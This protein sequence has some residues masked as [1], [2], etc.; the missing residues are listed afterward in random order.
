MPDPTPPPAPPRCALPWWRLALLMLPGLAG[1]SGL[2]FYPQSHLV[3]TPAQLGL[4]YRDVWL[5][6][7]DG[8]RLHGWWLPARG[9]PV[10]GT[11]YFLHG[12]AENIS[13]HIHNVQW[14]PDQ[15]YQVFLLDY[16]GYGRSTG[17]PRLPAVLQD[18]RTG[19]AYLLENPA[20]QG[21]PLFLLGQSLGASLGLYFAATDPQARR[22]LDGV[23][24]DA[25][26]ASYRGIVR[27]VAG[28]SWLTWPLQYP[29]AWRLPAGLDPVDHVA[30]IAPT[31]LLLIHSRQDPIIP[32]VNAERL[33]QAARQPVT[34]RTT[35]GPHTATFNH[36][37]H[38]RF[39]LSFFERSTTA[40]EAN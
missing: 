38:R 40:S 26:F 2:L 8:V 30:A 28:R 29:L 34:L 12:N 25:A 5:E 14:L 21:R 1:S 16:R 32:Y 7:A 23:I 22:R 31:P 19:F 33:Y 24:S 20:S 27:E 4:E 6:A 37:E 11:V 18:V 39:V 17:K 13:T 10:A 3:Q 36:P 15:G 9:G 35:L